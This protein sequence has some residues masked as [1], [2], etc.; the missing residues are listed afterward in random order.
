V[1]GYRS[2]D[3][4]VDIKGV[5]LNNIG[6]A[7]HAVKAKEA[8]EHYTRIDVIGQIPR[9]DSMHLAMRHL[10]LVPPPK[11]LFETMLFETAGKH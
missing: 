2:F 9:D 8:I 10:G 6:S 1:Q 3:R 5:I 11:G 4:R 7:T